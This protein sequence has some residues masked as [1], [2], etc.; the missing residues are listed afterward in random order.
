MIDT[1]CLG[2]YA[3]VAIDQVY[4]WTEEAWVEAGKMSTARYGH[5]VSTIM[6][7]EEV[8]QFCD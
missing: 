6:M 2:G 3:D 4:A 1:L 8:L 7:D 5:A